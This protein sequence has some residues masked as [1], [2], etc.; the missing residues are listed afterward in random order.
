MAE[1]IKYQQIEY[2]GTV[3]D[4]TAN[5]LVSP[6]Y[7]GHA[8]K[9]NNKVSE[10]LPEETQVTLCIEWLKTF[11]TPRKTVNDKIG[12]Y[13]L[14]HV[15]ERWA[16]IYISNGAFILAVYRMGYKIIPNYPLSPNT[17]FRLSYP[18]GL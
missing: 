11:A 16:G 13:G 15:V 17:R 9:R 8:V 14:K 2:Q 6:Q 7:R 3:Y 10:A 4:I 1:N 12:S 18:K 5:G